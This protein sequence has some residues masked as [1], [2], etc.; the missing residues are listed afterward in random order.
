MA[1]CLELKV[2]ACAL[3]P[4]FSVRFFGRASG[5][6]CNWLQYHN[7]ILLTYTSTA[8]RLHFACTLCFSF[9]ICTPELGVAVELP[10]CVSR[11]AFHG[12]A[13]TTAPTIPQQPQRAGCIT[14]LAS[15]GFRSI[16]N[17][18][19]QELCRAG[20]NGANTR[21]PSRSPY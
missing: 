10:V 7:E 4:T 9:A 3:E 1:E 20:T 19:L 11:P 16:G 8:G 12:L 13:P 5:G 2:A 15:V 18:S 21:L 17:T 6:R 14:F